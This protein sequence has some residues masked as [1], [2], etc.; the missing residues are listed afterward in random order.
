MWTLKKSVSALAEAGDMMQINLE[1]QSAA[2]RSFLSGNIYAERR[3]CRGRGWLLDDE[4]PRQTTSI[5]A[6]DE[7]RGIMTDLT[8]KNLARTA[9]NCLRNLGAKRR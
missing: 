8:M 7:A 1:D 4:I 6:L 5:L 2:G 3:G 9:V